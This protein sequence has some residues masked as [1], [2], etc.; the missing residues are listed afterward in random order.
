[1]RAILCVAAVALLVSGAAASSSNISSPYGSTGTDQ[2]IYGMNADGS[3]QVNLTNYE[4]E[5]SYPNWSPDGTKIAF[6][7]FRGQ[8]GDPEIVVMNA[9]GSNPVNIPNDL[10]EDFDPAWSPDGSRIVFSRSTGAH[11]HVY[12][13]N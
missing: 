12:V 2:E 9:D 4:N 1:M 5:D 6:T 11:F 7:S 8:F 13:M 3:D 10:A